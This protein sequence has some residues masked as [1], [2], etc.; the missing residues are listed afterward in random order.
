MKKLSYFFL[1]LPQSKQTTNKMRMSIG[2]AVVALLLTL[3]LGKVAIPVLDP[4]AGAQEYMIGAGKAD[5]TG[6]AAEGK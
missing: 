2:L 4:E 6:P 3:A 5:V 1:R